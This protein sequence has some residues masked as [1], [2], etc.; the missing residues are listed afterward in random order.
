M[1]I[2]ND[3]ESSRF[4]VVTGMVRMLTRGR[5]AKVYPPPQ[6][7]IIALKLFFSVYLYYE[8][9]YYYSPSEY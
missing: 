1:V 8:A 4:Y 6:Y 2:G 5:P 7:H 3:N 9:G